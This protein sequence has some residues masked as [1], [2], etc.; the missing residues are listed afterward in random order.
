MGLGEP[1]PIKVIVFNCGYL[2]GHSVLDC[3]DEGE[4]PLIGED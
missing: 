1:F 4:V 2:G 3:G